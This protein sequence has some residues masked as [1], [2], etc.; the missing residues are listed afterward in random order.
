MKLAVISVFSLRAGGQPSYFLLTSLYWLVV[1]MW[2]PYRREDA[3]R[4]E[5]DE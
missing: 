3:H 1:F 5:E 2:V 4:M